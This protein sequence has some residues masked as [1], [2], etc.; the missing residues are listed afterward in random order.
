MKSLSSILLTVAVLTTAGGALAADS[1]INDV[2]RDQRGNVIRNAFGNCVR[3]QWSVAN[4]FCGATV[5]ST[6]QQR[7]T[8]IL[9]SQEARTVYFDFNKSTLR[10]DAKRKLD[11]LASTLRSDTQV[12]QA[13][14]VGY[15]DRLGTVSYN[16]RLSQKRAQ[17]VRNYLI[18][19]GFINSRVA[20]TRWFGKSAPATSCPSNLS[21]ADL[22]DC[23]EKDRRVEIEIEYLPE[24]AA[25]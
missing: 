23:L 5:I 10:P 6:R 7:R 13:H 15:A 8:N 20:E 22:I 14:I 21:R 2:L 3:T 11:S 9:I 18:S 25:R 19:R 17:T 1:D 12:R 16:D 24:T 4:D